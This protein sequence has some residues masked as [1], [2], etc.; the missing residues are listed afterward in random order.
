MLSEARSSDQ[1]IA[2]L[3][4]VCEQPS[5]ADV[6]IVAANSRSLIANRGEL[7]REL[8]ARRLHVAAAVPR[9]D[10]L[11]ET[12]ELGVDVHL[13]EMSRTSPNPFSDLSYLLALVR[14]MRLTRPRVVFS[15][16]AKPVVYGS[17]A[18]RLAGVP[19]RYA[20]I[21]GLG[22]A[23][24]T[25]TPRTRAVRT[26][27]NVLYRAGLSSCHRVF[28]QNPDDLRELTASGVLRHRERT[29]RTNGSGV[30]LTRFPTQDLP[31]GPPLFLFIGRLLSEKGVAEFV[32]A[33]T[34]LRAKWPE[35]R[36]VV[37]GPHDATL[38]HAVAEDDLRRWVSDGVVEFVGAVADVR[39]W[40]A[41]CSVLVLPSY[42]EGTPRSVLEAMSTGRA[43]ITTD[44]P[45]CRET[46][47][48]GVN[49]YLVPP[50]SSWEL[51]AAMERFLEQPGLAGRLGVASR[52]LA[53]EKFDVRAVNRLI[54]ETMGL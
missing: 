36:F 51:A 28:F 5:G 29:M 39:P 37:V 18:A 11:P 53:E 34:T 43:I 4:P 23:Y 54:L 21:T 15:Y 1:R 40:L 50:R 47:V 31:S 25:D 10:Y 6:L 35:S 19:G 14:L 8:Q 22:H 26:V 41:E 45:G 27:L 42:R 2:Q 46:V 13:L 33:A 20:M 32:D 49:G 52:Q 9:R 38:P 44:A 48:E 7:I 30:D 16:S 17:L 12:S 3:P 24:T